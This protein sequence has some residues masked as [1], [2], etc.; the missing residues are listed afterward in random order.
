MD[1]VRWRLTELR[2][3]PVIVT[4]W[5]SWCPSCR[6]EFPALAATFNRHTRDGLLVL[7]VDQR[8][9][10]LR[11]ADVRQFLAAYPVPFPVLLDTRGRS[12]REYRLI[13]LPATVFIDTGGVIRSVLW[14]PH[15]QAEFERALALILSAAPV[16]PG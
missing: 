6:E 13:G 5:A 4:F 16:P 10:E 7:A 8:D 14:G 11:E 3:H 1:G 12:R 2:G 9:Q 15:T